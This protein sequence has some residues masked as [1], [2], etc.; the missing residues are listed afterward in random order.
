MNSSSS[1]PSIVQWV[2]KLS[3]SSIVFEEE[4]ARLKI[5]YEEAEEERQW[6]LPLGDYL[7]MY[8]YTCV[9]VCVCMVWW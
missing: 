4:D 2:K 7:G 9:C 5:D 6:T 3:G 1:S 8:I